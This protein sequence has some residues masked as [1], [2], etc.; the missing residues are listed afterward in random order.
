MLK[1]GTLRFPQKNYTGINWKYKTH[2]S[3][4]DKIS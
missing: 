4:T 3:K 2:A 1:V